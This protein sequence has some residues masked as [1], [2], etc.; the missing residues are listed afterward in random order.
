LLSGYAGAFNRR[1]HR[2]GHLFQN[3]Y[4]SIVVEEEPYLLELV[5]YLHLNP[6]R[7]HR[8]ESPQQWRWCSLA[9]YLHPGQYAWLYTQD[10]LACF[11]KR[12]RH[13]LLDFL[14]LASGL[15]S[16]AIY[17]C[18]SFPILN[19]TGTCS[20]IGLLGLLAILLMLWDL[21]LFWL[22]PYFLSAAIV[23]VGLLVLAAIIGFVHLGHLTTL[24]NLAPQI[25]Q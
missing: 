5:R 2:I 7:A 18:E 19:T 12:P 9:S 13:Q 24:S 21:N 15:D 3:R 17:P 11:G 8:V 20:F 23:I 1:H 25:E 16:A 22:G 6:V 10:V 4:K 14:S